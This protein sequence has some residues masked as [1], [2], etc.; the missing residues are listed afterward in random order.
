MAENTGPNQSAISARIE[1]SDSQTPSA[2]IQ[3]RLRG[4]PATPLGGTWYAR[5]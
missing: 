4:N 2:A 3:S 5:S 1:L